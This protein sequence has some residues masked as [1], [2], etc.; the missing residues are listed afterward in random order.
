MD[1]VADIGQRTEGHSLDDLGGEGLL[2]LPQAI[3]QM[4]AIVFQTGEEASARDGRQSEVLH[5]A[6]K[7][8][9]VENLPFAAPS[10][11]KK[12]RVVEPGIV[13]DEVND[14]GRAAILVR[15]NDSPVDEVAL[16]R[17]AE[18]QG[19]NSRGIAAQKALALG[20]QLPPDVAAE[21]APTATH[22]CPVILNVPLPANQGELDSVKDGGF[23]HSV[24]ADEVGG[25]LA[26]DGRVLEQMP[27]DQA[28]TC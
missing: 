5:V 16:I 19:D 9:T 26:G 8:A 10:T 15:V 24:D 7:S 23:A 4:K 20:A 14:V 12:P 13:D 18:L 1:K 11:V 28:D 6:P 25:P 21:R 22:R 17:V 3:E 27:V 2:E